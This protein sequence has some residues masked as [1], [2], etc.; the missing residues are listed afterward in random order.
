MTS[1]GSSAPEVVAPVAPPAVLSGPVAVCVDRPL[2]SLDRPFTYELPAELEA[3]VGSLVQVPFH[4]RATR[5]WV[6]GPTGDVPARI[7]PVRRAVSGVRSFDARGLELLRW[8]SARYVAPLAAVIG[9]A[10]P[11]RVAS[12]EEGRLGVAAATPAV[13]PPGD[14]RRDGPLEAYRGG[15]SL[16]AAINRGTGGFVLRPA[17]EDEQAVAVEA[18]GACL[19]GGRRAL[20]LVPEASPTPATAAA[21]LDAFGPRAV[22]FL[23]GDKRTRY[24]TWLDLVEGRHDVV[25]GT[26]PA[27]YA[28]LGSLGLVYVS[29]ESHPA[30]RE[31][32]APYSHVREVGLAAARLAG[33]VCV[34]S[35]LC[36][37]AEAAAAGLPEVAPS[38]RRWPPVEVV[39]PGPEGRA[40]RLV[41]ALAE[42]RRAFLFSP[43]PGYGVAQVCR[44]CGEPAACAACG[45]LLRSS[46]GAVTCVVCGAAGRCRACGAASF[47]VRRGG[48]ER[49]EEWAARIAPVPVRRLADGEAPK[50]PG[51]AEV[52]VG[53]PDHVRDLGPGG[54][55]LVAI[56]D[57]DLAGRRPGIA[58]RE[59]SLATWIEAAAW[60]RPRG[61]VVVQA[62]SPSDPIVQALV[63]GNPDRF[64]ADEAARRAEAGLPVGSAVFRVAGGPGLERE[65]RALEPTTLL[66]TSS[67][68][69]TVCLLALDPRRVA[70]LGA[71]LRA[72]AVEGVVE[73]VEA[74]PHL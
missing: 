4:G 48:A 54:L 2:L 70:T 28:P 15:G 73:R 27:V 69:R 10:V 24:R 13:E 35:G 30:H 32:R 39:R 20:V 5:G 43:L 41:Q 52:L 42:A 59:R 46:E 23:G 63:R 29:R 64:H 44:A 40:P 9:R 16:L 26:R 36:P 11:P 25:V 22:A 51:E 71:R 62:S 3:G 31:D 68:D 72:L 57:A 66:V 33:G 74:E 56:L 17:P 47:G 50:L 49:V 67:Q 7:L 1:A 55:D 34:L 21:V 65:L 53:G 61:R 58:A 19:A 38:S 18:V 14:A 12:E 8:V 60:A 45:G 37:S 6:L